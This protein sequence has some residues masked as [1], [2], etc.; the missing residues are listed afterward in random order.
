MFFLYGMEN[1]N[2]SLFCYSD[3][4]MTGTYDWNINELNE[5]FATDTDR[6][7]QPGQ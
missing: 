6:E 2:I 7:G 5:D 1:K 4:P 3:K